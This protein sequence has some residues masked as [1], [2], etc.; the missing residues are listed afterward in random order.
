MFEHINR[1]TLAVIPFSY[2]LKQE[3]TNMVKLFFSYIHL[4]CQSQE[5]RL[6]WLA[7]RKRSKPRSV[8]ISIL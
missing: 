1:I 4:L 5:A 3:S 2:V 7:V 6:L 8:V